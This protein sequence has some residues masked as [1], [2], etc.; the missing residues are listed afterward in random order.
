M[1]KSF[2][3]LINSIVLLLKII[4]RNS[5]QLTFPPITLSNPKQ[6]NE[7]LLLEEVRHVAQSYS[8]LQLIAATRVGS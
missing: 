7:K 3:V 5:N 6:F 8:Y 1:E 4:N 2:F